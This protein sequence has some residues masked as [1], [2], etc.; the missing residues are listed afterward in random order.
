MNPFNSDAIKLIFVFFVPG[1]ISMK[2]YDL[3]IPSERRDYSKSLMEAIS[4]SCFNFAI[5]YWIWTLINSDNFSTINSF[6]YYL[7]LIEILFIIP[8]LLPIIFLRIIK[9]PFILNKIINP[10]SKPWDYVF[11]KREYFWVII[12]LKDGRRIGGKYDTNSFT[13]SFPAEEQIY[14]EEVW[15]LGE[16]G[17]F[18]EKV[19]DSRGLIISSKDFEAI[20][21]FKT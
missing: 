19:E 7:L 14:I 4:F 2:V 12:H 15:K 18:I 9:L 3:F 6:W 8:I 20:E 13:S 21:F 5:N 16:K 17:D 11:S 10:F 1:F